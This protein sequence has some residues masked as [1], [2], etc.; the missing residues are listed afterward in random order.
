[1]GKITEPWEIRIRNLQTTRAALWS[2]IE[3]ALQYDRHNLRYIRRLIWV[4]SDVYNRLSDLEWSCEA[5]MVNSLRD[6][7]WIFD[8]W[9]DGRRLYILWTPEEVECLVS[10]MYGGMD[11]VREVA[12][13]LGRSVSAVA[14]KRTYIR[15]NMELYGQA[16]RPQR[17]RGSGGRYVRAVPRPRFE[18]ENG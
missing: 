2:L 11:A 1:M 3:E 8:K 4:W 18:R 5:S 15:R 9:P 6:R 14:T 10:R 13:L 12:E 17:A 7:G 16:T